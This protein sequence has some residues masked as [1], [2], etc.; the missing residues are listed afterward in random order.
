MTVKVALAAASV[1]AT[2]L[3]AK[4]GV[5]SSSVIVSVPVASEIVALAGL[6]SVSVAVSLA[7]S[8]LSARTPTVKV[9][10]VAP[11]AMVNWLSF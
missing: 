1:I 11:A 4:V 7:S 2:S 8:R 5:A 10:V 3:I 9:A 6:D